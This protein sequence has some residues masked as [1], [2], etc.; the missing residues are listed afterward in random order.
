MEL[1][2]RPQGCPVAFAVWNG[3]T[4]DRDGLKYFSIWYVLSK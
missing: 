2:D 4:G 1:P 3:A